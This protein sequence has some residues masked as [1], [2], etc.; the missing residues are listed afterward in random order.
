ML[1]DD[2]IQ[3]LYQ[4]WEDERCITRADMQSL[5]DQAREAN[6]L[7]A[8]VEG[9]RSSGDAKDLALQWAAGG[10]ARL[11]AEIADAEKV[12]GIAY[13]RI[14]QMNVELSETRQLVSLL[15]NQLAEMHKV[16]EAARHWAHASPYDDTT[17]VDDLLT[18]ALVNYDDWLS[19]NPHANYLKTVSGK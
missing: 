17:Q 10:V 18:D 16:V 8:E 13:E 11:R 2:E 19:Q 12:K 9:L 7:R 15:G 6:A 1:N 4:E 3:K 14:A 5:R